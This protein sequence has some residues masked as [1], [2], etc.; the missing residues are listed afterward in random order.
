VTLGKNEHTDKKQA[1]RKVGII[2][3]R[4]Q[5]EKKWDMKMK[6][7][8]GEPRGGRRKKRR[9]LRFQYHPEDIA[10]SIL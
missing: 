5:G 1:M 7:N 9:S 10:R 8:L 2:A 3:D 6:R 4:E